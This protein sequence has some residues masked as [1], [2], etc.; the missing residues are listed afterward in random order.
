MKRILGLDLGTNSIG[1]AVLS[2]EENNDNLF[3]KKIEAT[4]CRIIPM[5]ASILG[6]FDRGNSISQTAERTRLRSARHLTERSQQRRER[7]HR[8]LDIIAFLPE[9]YSQA[10]NRYGKIKDG[11]EPKLAWRKNKYGKYE[12]L[13]V[14]SFNEMLEEFRTLHP[15]FSNKKV[16]YDWN[17]L[18]T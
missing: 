6:D 15:E 9:H 16:P 10:L 17:I 1:W 2:A 7:L 8:V 4:G 18:S 5:D 3:L 14:E 12:F 13:F 11:E